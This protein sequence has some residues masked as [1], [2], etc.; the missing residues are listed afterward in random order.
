MLPSGYKQSVGKENVK[1]EANA[2]PSASHNKKWARANQTEFYRMV[3][4]LMPREV[5]AKVSTQFTLLDAL[6]EMEEHLK[7]KK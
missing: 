2:S 1:A 7:D 6:M 5:E 4:R 3:A